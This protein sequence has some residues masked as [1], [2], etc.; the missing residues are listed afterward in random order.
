ML[1]IWWKLFTIY[2]ADC[3]NMVLSWNI[4]IYLNR[5][6]LERFC[7]DGLILNTLKR[8]CSLQASDWWSVNEN[9]IGWL[10]TS[11]PALNW[12]QCDFSAR[13]FWENSE[14][15]APTSSKQ[16][17]SCRRA[18]MFPP[19]LRTSGYL[20]AGPHTCVWAMERPP[21][22]RVVMW[23][24]SRSTLGC[25]SGNHTARHETSPLVCSSRSE[26]SCWWVGPFVELNITSLLC[27]NPV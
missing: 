24:D 8:Y 11:C 22:R 10:I 14:Q 21:R 9:V 20:A 15:T 4:I 16:V 17:E 12:C 1:P 5:S 7:G 25:Y 3:I 19:S 13:Q 27:I 26:P 2:F 18:R 6:D 23:T